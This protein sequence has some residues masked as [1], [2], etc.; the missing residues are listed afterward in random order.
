MPKRKNPN[1]FKFSKLPFV[2]LRGVFVGLLTGLPIALLMG[3][4]LFESMRD[5]F[6]ANLGGNIGSF[7]H[8]LF[9][10]FTYKLAI[11][12]EPIPGA[13]SWLGRHADAMRKAGNAWNWDMHQ[14]GQFSVE[15]W[16][17]ENQ[18]RA[19]SIIEFSIVICISLAILF[20]LARVFKSSKSDGA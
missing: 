13:L 9:E 3:R 11:L 7:W 12:I 20:Y 2:A 1:R 14:Y 6:S 18:S 5:S 8:Y 15:Y 19:Y 10:Y 17:L 4:S 16:L